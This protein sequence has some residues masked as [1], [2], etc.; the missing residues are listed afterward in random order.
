MSTKDRILP[1]ILVAI[2]AVG[3]LGM[4]FLLPWAEYGLLSGQSSMSEFGKQL[5]TTL[6]LTGLID[7]VSGFTASTFPDLKSDANAAYYVYG[8]FLGLALISAA[9]GINVIGREDSEEKTVLPLK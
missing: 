2:F 3:C 1:I 4:T 6:G 9:I 8:F 7:A 5:A